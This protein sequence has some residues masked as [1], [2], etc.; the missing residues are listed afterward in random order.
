MHHSPTLS[1]THTH[2]K[3]PQP[4][5]I[6]KH[7]TPAHTHIMGHTH[8]HT[9]LPQLPEMPSHYSADLC[10]LI[11]RM[12]AQAADDRPSVQ[13]LL[14]MHFVRQHIKHFLEKASQ[15]KA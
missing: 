8:T 7:G 10:D 2:C 11:R 5:L 1:L 9:T 12:L 4:H 3:H 6:A 13:E 15:K 14:R